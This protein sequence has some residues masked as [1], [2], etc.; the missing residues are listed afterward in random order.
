MRMGF[1]TPRTT[2][3]TANGNYLEVLMNR[4]E[5]VVTGTLAA[6]ASAIYKDAP[7]A[8]PKVGGATYQAFVLPWRYQK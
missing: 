3:P 5:L 2:G 6:L 8:A 1:S 7:A 4:R